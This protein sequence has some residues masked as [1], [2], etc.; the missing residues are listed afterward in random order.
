MALASPDKDCHWLSWAHAEYGTAVRAKPKSK[1]Q[2][3][4]GIL[5]VSLKLA[6]R[7]V[8]PEKNRIFGTFFNKYNL[9]IFK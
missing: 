8:C 9:H 6:K 7:P 3:Q 5:S 1:R 4:Q 2:T